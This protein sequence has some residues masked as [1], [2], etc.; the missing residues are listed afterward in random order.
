MADEGPYSLEA[1]ILSF[2]RDLEELAPG[3]FQ[4]ALDRLV[5]GDAAAP[6]LDLGDIRFLP[7]QHVAD[8]QAAADRCLRGGRSLTVFAKRNVATML[9]RM[10]LGAVARVK[11]T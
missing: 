5:S 7:S 6:V 1:G 11:S 8:I 3:R 2:N 10:G 4:E 9:E